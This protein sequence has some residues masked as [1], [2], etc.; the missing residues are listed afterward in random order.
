L[1]CTIL[2][3]FAYIP[4]RPGA[5]HSLNRQLKRYFNSCDHL[6]KYRE[7]EENLQGGFLGRL[8][9]N[10]HI[11]QILRLPDRMGMWV[12]HLQPAEKTDQKAAV[13][14][15][16]HNLQALSYRIIELN[17]VRSKLRPEDSIS[18]LKQEV[19]DWRYDVH[20][21]LQQ[22]HTDPAAISPSAFAKKQ[23]AMMNQL[24]KNVEKEIDNPKG[25]TLSNQATEMYYLLLGGYRGVAVAL[26]ACTKSAA[27]IDWQLFDS[28]EKQERR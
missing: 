19:D 25:K 27:T 22:L 15:M 6:M 4:L 20:R 28:E 18:D 13:R 21:T 2:T 26:S 24:D 3:I 11:R 8:R 14:E 7:P 17:K 1:T 5:E 9:D 23:L 10:F 16:L 12:A